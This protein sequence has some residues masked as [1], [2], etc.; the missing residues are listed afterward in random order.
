MENRNNMTAK[1]EKKSV[2][3]GGRGWT[4]RKGF[5]I[6]GDYIDNEPIFC[7]TMTQAREVF[8]TLAT[9]K[10]CM[11]FNAYLRDHEKETFISMVNAGKYKQAMEFWDELV[12]SDELRIIKGT[13]IVPSV[14]V[15]PSPVLAGVTGT[16]LILEKSIEEKKQETL[17]FTTEK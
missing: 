15:A 14:I 1:E 5:A 6:T 3:N 16:P 17:N 13:M 7:S 11:S 4:S 10:K 9:D 12:A 8:C 2:G